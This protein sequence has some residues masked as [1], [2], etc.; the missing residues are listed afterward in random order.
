M[1]IL[2]I[3]T[4]TDILD[5]AIIRNGSLIA[6]YTIH[7]KD[8]THSALIIPALKNTL[9]IV[10]LDLKNIEGI[11][12]AIGPGSFTGLRIGLATALGLCFSLKIPIVGVNTLDAYALQWKEFPG[13]LCPLIKAR[14]DEYYFALF[15]KDRAEE[16][17]QHHLA[18]IED[19]QC[20]PWIN[21]QEK[22]L[23]YGEH[24]YMFGYGLED[25]VVDE[26]NETIRN[27]IHFVDRGQNPPGAVPIA[28]LGE[29]K[30]L[31]GRP[32]DMFT[33]SPFYLHRSAA[34]LKKRSR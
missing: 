29:R 17:A 15:R 34:E 11:A 30:I 31:N 20:C 3:D 24:V 13:L 4:S 27:H 26:K 32:D 12:V 10:K 23:K 1:V 25:I 18:K 22:L 2:G 6:G 9:D 5:L 19:Y 7:Q 21:I 16:K 8:I 14:K 28:S 33:L